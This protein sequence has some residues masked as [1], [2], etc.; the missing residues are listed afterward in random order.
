MNIIVLLD[1]P[2]KNDGRVRRVIESLS[3]NNKVYLYYINGTK[4]DEKLF[5]SNCTLLSFSKIN[6]WIY[7]NIFF[8][9]CFTLLEKELLKFNQ[10]I[11]IIYCNDYPLLKTAVNLKCLHP[12]SKIY[13]D[14]HEIYIET[15]NQFFPTT[16]W[17]MVY[18]LIL[19][20]INKKIHT[21]FERKYIKNIHLFITVC[22]SLKNYF[23]KIYNISNIIVV[24]NCPTSNIKINNKIDLRKE[25]SFANED[26]IVLYQGVLNNG[27]GIEKL[28]EASLS[29]ESHI[30]FVIIGE[31]PNFLQYKQ[32]VQSR[33]INNIYFIGKVRFDIL[34]DYTATADL[35]L[36]FIQSI[37]I[38]KRY[39][40]PNKI[41]EYM[42]VGLPYLSNDLPESVKII[43]ECNCGIIIDDTYP[44]NIAI[45][46]NKLSYK[47]DDIKKLGEN[48]RK[49]YELKYNWESEINKLLQEI[50]DI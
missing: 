14:S 16:G 6:N 35:G 5:N 20:F 39:A 49:C 23:Q 48:G 46:I 27:R 47:R 19:I 12:D 7:K 24:R 37:N 41:F 38:S 45:E 36:L 33:D 9:K 50:N 40:L 11:D 10:K 44:I 22:D 15:I 25:L 21:Y 31:G 32:M 30:K 13:Y 1:G 28:I 3:V 8:N 17:K 43:N 4:D 18:G 29:F 26:F 34:L 2:I 42:S